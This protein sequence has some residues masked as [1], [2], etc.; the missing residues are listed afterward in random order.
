MVA[1]RMKSLP[2][3]TTEN[4]LYTKRQLINVVQGTHNSRN[5]NFVGPVR[6]RQNKLGQIRINQSI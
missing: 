6:I 3:A 1:N 4:I 2:C 5:T